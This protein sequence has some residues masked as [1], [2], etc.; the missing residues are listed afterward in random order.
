MNYRAERFNNSMRSLEAMVSDFKDASKASIFSDKGAGVG[1]L[2]SEIDANGQDARSTCNAGTGANGQGAR[3]T[4]DSSRK[5]LLRAAERK[6]RRAGRGYLVPVLRLI[7]K[8]GSARYL[9]LEKISRASYFRHR[10]EL[11]RF[12]S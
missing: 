5:A 2:V 12:F 1:R 7:V 3:S 10:G 9:S 11:L 6:L 8:N 4:T